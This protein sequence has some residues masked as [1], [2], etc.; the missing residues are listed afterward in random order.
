[1]SYHLPQCPWDGQTAH[2][3]PKEKP[4]PPP[5][6]EQKSEDTQISGEPDTEVT[7]PPKA[8]G[9]GGGGARE[10]LLPGGRPE[11][12]ATALIL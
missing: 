2:S 9:S 10:I 5:A 11:P 8:E 6:A 12:L 3:E 1:M 4:A 7:G